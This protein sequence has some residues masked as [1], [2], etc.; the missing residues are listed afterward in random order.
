M[1]TN[2]WFKFFNHTHDIDN[3]CNKS[4]KYMIPENIKDKWK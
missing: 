1:N 4:R 2:S 3:L